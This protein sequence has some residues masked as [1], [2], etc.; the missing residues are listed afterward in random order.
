MI[1]IGITGGIGS[2]K[3]TISNILKEMGYPVFDCDKKA[4][5]LCDIDP[6]VMK[7]IRDAFGKDIYVNNILNREKL[8]RIV[9]NDKE[10]LDKLNSIVHPKTREYMY[11]FIIA[12]MDND[13]CFVESAIMFE[14]ELNK[15]MDK[16]ISVTAP[17]DVRI[18]RVIKRDNTTKEKVLERI[19]NQMNEEERLLQSDIIISTHQPL[20]NV[21]EILSHLVETIN[22]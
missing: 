8:A 1:V 3:T 20:D 16:I 17:Q 18:D 19:N 7:N 22:E 6:Y 10:S 21:K 15:L 9:F 2:G 14:S 5:F 12:Q 4:K 11:D 13:I